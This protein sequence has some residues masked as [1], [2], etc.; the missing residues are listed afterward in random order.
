MVAKFSCIECEQVIKPGLQ[1][2]CECGGLLEVIHEFPKVDKVLFDRRLSQHNNLLG[3]GVWR[4]KELIYPELREDQIV[5][6]QE[7]NTGIYYHN[8]LSRYT[9][10]EHITTKHEGE[11]PSGS[12]KDRGMTVGISEALRLGVNTVA[13]ASTGNTSASIASYAAYSGLNCTVFIPE[14]MI[15]YGKLAQALS[16]GATVLQIRGD[17]DAAMSLVQ[18]ASKKMGLYLLNSVN[19]WRIEGQKSIMFELIQQRKWIPP[20]WVVFPAGNLGNASAFGKALGEM[21]S[22]GIIDDLPRLAS[23][24]AEGANPF[25]SLWINQEESLK[26]IVPQTI[27]SAIKIGNPVSWKKAKRAIEETNGVVE[28]VSDQEIMDAKAVVDGCGI[29]CEPAS[30]AS[31]AGAKKLMEKGIIDSNDS[32]VCILTGNLLKDPEATVNYHKGV[33][34]GISP[35]FSNTPLVVNADLVSVKEALAKSKRID[36]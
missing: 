15:A 30:A 17:F 14:R 16:Y 24:Q 7:G 32:V 10:I 22:L 29:G 9:G 19:P 4:F 13:C 33:I 3:S 2:K 28:Q 25:Y 23:I 35:T 11:N 27:A 12:F 36:A 18:Y 31:I 1:L 26:S 5:S 20:D 34:K 21:K 8:R 6:R